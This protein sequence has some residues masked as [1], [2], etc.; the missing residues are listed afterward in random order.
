MIYKLLITVT[1]TFFLCSC[2]VVDKAFYTMTLAGQAVGTTFEAGKSAVELTAKTVG[3]AGKATKATYR[4]FERKK[5]VPLERVGNSYY[6][7]VRFNDKINRKLIL[8]TGAS[9]TQ[10]SG[11]IARKLRLDLSKAKQVRVVLADGSQNVAYKLNIQSIKVGSLKLKNTPV[12]ILGQ[13]YSSADNGLLGMSFLQNFYF[14]IDARN[15]QLIMKGI[16]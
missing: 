10:I 4:A 7:N 15:N 3:Y 2:T 5:V 14:E 9:T 16:R 6:V 8:D 11:E 12:L 13:E 1:A